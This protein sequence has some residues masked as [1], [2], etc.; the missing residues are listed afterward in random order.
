MLI[1]SLADE[2]VTVVIHHRLRIE[3]NDSDSHDTLNTFLCKSVLFVVTTE[4]LHQVKFQ[5]LISIKLVLLH[6]IEISSAN[7]GKL[8]KPLIGK[9]VLLLPLLVSEV[10]PEI[11]R[12]QHNSSSH[13]I[14]EILIV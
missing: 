1:N 3:D 4:I 13:K 8:A 11:V 14:G 5:S 6:A 9:D 2:I 12:V 10:L 7:F